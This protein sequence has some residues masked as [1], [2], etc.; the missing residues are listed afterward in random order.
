MFQKWFLL[1]CIST[2]LLLEGANSGQAPSKRSLP[3][4]LQEIEAKYTKAST[5]TADFSQTNNDMALGQKKTSSGKIF[6][7]RPSKMRWE[8]TKPD[9]S[10]LVSNG[11]SFW[12]YTPPFDEGERGQVIE[13][14]S[15]EIQSK[16]ANALLSGSFS[17][18]RDM[19][20]REKTPSLYLLIPKAG[21]A[22]TV[23]Q[24]TIEVDR[25]KKLIQKVILDHKGGNRSEVA[26]SQIELGKPLK[27]ELFNFKAPPNTDYL[28]E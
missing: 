27:E 20:I 7:K 2:C 15:A 17:M 1:S 21:T 13:K 24:A 26:L 5:L 25:D 4:L 14:K 9:S 6:V 8:T 19:V 23:T 22:G 12:F 18:A 10:L 16:L 28:D 3:P 11:M